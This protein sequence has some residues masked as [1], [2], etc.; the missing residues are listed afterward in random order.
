MEKCGILSTFKGLPYRCRKNAKYIVEM[1][2]FHFREEHFRVL[3]KMCECHA[4]RYN[5]MCGNIIH[6]K[7]KNKKK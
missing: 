3:T 1:T 7:I 6:S 2:S 4:K 5:S